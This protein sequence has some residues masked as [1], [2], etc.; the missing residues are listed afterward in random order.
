MVILGTVT[1]LAVV[2]ADGG[3]LVG[4][5]AGALTG[6]ECTATATAVATDATGNTA[7][8]TRSFEVDTQTSA[9]F[10]TADAGLTF[11]VTFEDKKRAATVAKNA[12][13]SVVFAANEGLAG[14]YETA[15]SM[16]VSDLAGNTSAITD[17][18][19]VDTRAPMA[20][21]ALRACLDTDTDTGIT[22]VTRGA[23]GCLRGADEADATVDPSQPGVAR[24]AEMQDGSQSPITVALLSRRTVLEDGAFQTVAAAVLAEDTDDHVL[25]ALDLYITAETARARAAVNKSA[26]ARMERLEYAMSERVQGGII[27]RANL[28]IMSIFPKFMRVQLTFCREIAASAMSELAT[29][30]A[31]PLV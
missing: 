14:S 4:M 7:A 20:L 24:D 18:F 31:R 12:S 1:L 13:W 25:A 15:V 28:H 22:D 3:W 8:T 23:F 29:T 5:P 9:S 26:M 21:L 30:S 2:A 11:M 17:T 16:L 19:E 27:K 6:G 10:G